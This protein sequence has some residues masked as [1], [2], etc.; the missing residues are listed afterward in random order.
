VRGR[1][2]ASQRRPQGR[3]E[4]SPRRRGEAISGIRRV[5]VLRGVC[6]GAAGRRGASCKTAR[7]FRDC[8]AALATTVGGGRCEPSRQRGAAIWGGVVRRCVPLTV[9]AIWGVTGL[10]RRDVKDCHGPRPRN[11]RREPLYANNP[12]AWDSPALFPVPC[13]LFLVPSSPP[14]NL[15]YHARVIPHDQPVMGGG[16]FGFIAQGRKRWKEATRDTRYP[17]KSSPS[18]S[19]SNLGRGRRGKV[20]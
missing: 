17:L 8:F 12:P 13:S 7:P 4:P 14:V 11:D 10:R 2:P 5:L 20:T 18:A 15:L 6:R 9:R 1:R 16:R 3:C 19:R